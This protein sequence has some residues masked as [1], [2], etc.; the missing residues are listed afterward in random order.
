M[1]PPAAR[2]A[3]VPNTEPGDLIIAPRRSLCTFVH[4][5]EE[6]CRPATLHLHFPE[7]WEGRGAAEEPGSG[8][9]YISQL[10]VQADG[11]KGWLEISLR[12]LTVRLSLQRKLLKAGT[13]G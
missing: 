8:N 13:G 7:I 9:G 1:W 5:G 3:C 11:V 6:L 10:L 2:W 4:S 12:S